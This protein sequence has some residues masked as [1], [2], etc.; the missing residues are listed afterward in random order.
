[1]EP[2]YTKVAKQLSNL[3]ILPSLHCVLWVLLTK[4]KRTE[5]NSVQVTAARVLHRAQPQSRGWVTET[6]FPCLHRKKDR[7]PE[8]MGASSRAEPQ[9]TH[10]SKAFQA[11]NEYFASR[12]KKHTFY[13]E[14]GSR[15]A[16][17]GLESLDSRND[18]ELRILPSL[19][20]TF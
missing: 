18:A 11:L 13:F 10:L 4:R 19:P 14:T 16:Q 15:A 8:A 2:A 1:M 7:G 20:P 12:P 3:F 6:L 17:D 5:W 9:R